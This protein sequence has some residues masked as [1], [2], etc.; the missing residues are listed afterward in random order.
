MK[1][2]LDILAVDDHFDYLAPMK[3]LLQSDGHSTIGVTSANE[4]LEQLRQTNFDLMIIDI[5]LAD[6]DG[7]ELCRQARQLNP[8]ATI[9][10][11]SACI[12]N[13]DRQRGYDAGATMYLP[14][15]EG[16]ETILSVANMMRNSSG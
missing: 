8:K 16:M 5:H 2:T 10:I 11:H 1:T 12:Q 9:V 6:M 4:A 3:L 14:K 15:P 13:Q 7:I